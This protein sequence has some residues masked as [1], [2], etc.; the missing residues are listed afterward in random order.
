MATFEG[1]LLSIKSVSA[2]ARRRPPTPTSG[3]A[4]SGSSSTSSPCGSRARRK[5]SCCAPPTP[6]GPWSPLRRDGA[7]H[8]P[9]VHRARRRRRHVPGRLHH[10]G[11]ESVE[12]RPRRRARHRDDR[13]GGRG[14]VSGAGGVRAARRAQGA[15]PWFSLVAIGAVAML[16]VA[17]PVRAVLIMGFVLLLGEL[18]WIVARRDREAGKPSWFG[19]VE[20]RPLS[21][22]VLTLIAVLIGGVAELMPTLPVKQAVPGPHRQRPAPVHGPRAGRT[23]HLPARGRL[24]VSL[25]NGA[26][27]HRRYGAL[28]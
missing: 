19:L 20:R 14:S 16:G 18:A 1:P 17:Q 23:G 27:P 7:G 13:G 22:T 2:L 26:D 10:D 3:S 5:A 9:D 25:A 4:P 21:F 15:A 8:P 12:D 28:R 24:L 11:L 6:T